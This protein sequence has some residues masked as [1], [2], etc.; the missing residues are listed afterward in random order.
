MNRDIKHLR[1]IIQSCN[2]IEEAVLMFGA[3]EEDYLSNKQYQNSCAFALLQIG[4]I[5]KRL[6][7]DLISSHPE[8]EWSDIAKFRDVLTHSYS[9]VELPAVWNVI[10]EDVP[11]LKKE[12]ESIL[13]ELTSK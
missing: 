4:E 1:S 7:P 3:D 8:I 2:E 6:S 9:K 5:V 11:S 12:C 10:T 13:T